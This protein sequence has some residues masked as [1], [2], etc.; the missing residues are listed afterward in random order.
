MAPEPG[1][2]AEIHIGFLTIF[3]LLFPDMADPGGNALK[4]GVS[5]RMAGRKIP[6]SSDPSVKKWREVVVWGRRGR[7]SPHA[8]RWATAFWSWPLS[9]ARFLPDWCAAFPEV[10][11][12]RRR[13]CV[14]CER[15]GFC[16]RIIRTG[17]AA[18][19][20]GGKRKNACWPTALSVLAFT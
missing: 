15:A 7:I 2:E 11:A 9:A 4:Q 10:G 13:C 1:E 19:A 8:I 3:A 12:T 16:G 17:Y 14:P 18:I 5:G 6:R 20:L